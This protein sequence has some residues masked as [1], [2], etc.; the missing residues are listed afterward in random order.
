MSLAMLLLLFI[1][2]DTLTEEYAQYQ[3]SNAASNYENIYSSSSS[4]EFDFPTWNTQS[5]ATLY[6]ST[7]G[8]IT[9]E[10]ILFVALLRI[11]NVTGRSYFA[12]HL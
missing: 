9:S 8:R 10:F 6:P 2:G 11:R 7:A 12:D 1:S 4:S 5:P 3:L